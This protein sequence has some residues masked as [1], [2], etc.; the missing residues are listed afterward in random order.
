MEVSPDNTKPPIKHL[1][2]SAWES[3]SMH[4]IWKRCSACLCPPFQGLCTAN[5]PLHNPHSINSVP[6]LHSPW[7]WCFPQEISTPGGTSGP[8]HSKRI[9]SLGRCWT[10][11]PE[12]PECDGQGCWKVQEHLVLIFLF[13]TPFA[14]P[15][16]PHLLINTT[17]PLSPDI[18]IVCMAS[19]ITKQAAVT[20]TSRVRRNL[21][22]PSSTPPPTAAE[23][24]SEGQIDYWI[25]M[26]LWI[27]LLDLPIKNPEVIIPALFTRIWIVACWARTPS[28]AAFTS[29]SR[30]TSH[31]KA[32]KRPG[33]VTFV[34]NSWL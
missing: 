24:P 20:F 19:R 5:Q 10:L 17:W 6:S 27:T 13:T 14:C 8:F 12:R 2:S 3:H 15:H 9:S 21:S 33:P 30:V 26:Y 11:A 34:A 28:K 18:I 25:I 23:R 4:P 31:F 16:I 1:L 32:I 22:I 7:T 29:A